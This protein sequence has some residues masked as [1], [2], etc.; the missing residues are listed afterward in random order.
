MTTPP[1]PPAARPAPVAG[2]GVELLFL[3]DED[4]RQAQELLLLAC[5][6]FGNVIDP[7]LHEYGLG[8]AHYRIM[9]TVALQPGIAVGALLDVLGITKQSM[10]RTLGELVAHGLLRHETTPQDRRRRCLHLSA[11]GAEIENRLFSLQR[12]VLLRVYRNAGGR[13]VDG[14]RRVMRGLIDESAMPGV[15]TDAFHPPDRSSS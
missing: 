9:Q 6:A 13:A 11:R 7:A 15:S 8:H 5:R 10:S 4:M 3:R 1:R 14:F 2:A 12:E